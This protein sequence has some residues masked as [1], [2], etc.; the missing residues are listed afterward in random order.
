MNRNLNIVRGYVVR[1]PRRSQG[2]HRVF[3]ALCNCHHVQRHQWTI[4]TRSLAAD[5]HSRARIRLAIRLVTTTAI[6][7]TARLFVRAIGRIC[8]LAS[9]ALGSTRMLQH[10]RDAQHGH[11]PEGPS[12]HQDGKVA[13]SHRNIID[14]PG[15][16]RQPFPRNFAVTMP[17]GM[18][19]SRYSVS[20]QRP[21]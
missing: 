19:V 9:F 14:D 16:D 7:R 8:F 13:Q 1:Y 15:H 18:P 10:T 17:F 20:G 6:V 3:S 21:P 11:A 2:L 5:E 12:G 4:V